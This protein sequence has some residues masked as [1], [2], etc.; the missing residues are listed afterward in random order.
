MAP[1]TDPMLVG[2]NLTAAWTRGSA[3]SVITRFCPPHLAACNGV[4]LD[5]HV[6]LGRL[7][8]DLKWLLALDTNHQSW[9][10]IL[11]QR[12]VSLPPSRRTGRCRNRSCTRLCTCTSR[13]PWCRP[14]RSPPSPWGCPGPRP[15]PAPAC[16]DSGCSVRAHWC[17]TG[18]DQPRIE[19]N[20]FVSCKSHCSHD[21]RPCLRWCWRAL[22][23][24]GPARGAGV[25][26]RTGL[27]PCLKVSSQACLIICP[28]SAPRW[29]SPP[30]PDQ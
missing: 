1:S 28:Q 22:A 3:M 24:R 11:C 15:A 8:H 5:N 16:P 21:I 9:D 18:R 27:C 4:H 23:W 2:S 7:H 19:D 6:K 13:S 10:I 25:W 12:Y 29:S 14:A 20:H 26:S 17:S 30:V